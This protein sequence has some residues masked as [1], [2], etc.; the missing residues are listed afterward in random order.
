MARLRITLG[1]SVLLIVGLVLALEIVLFVLTW[2]SN[3]KVPENY[4][5]S[6]LAAKITFISLLTATI[7][8]LHRLFLD[9]VRNVSRS[10]ASGPTSPGES[11][12]AKAS[13]LAAIV[14]EYRFYYLL[15]FSAILTTFV[16]IL[17]DTYI[18]VGSTA[19]TLQVLSLS[20]AESGLVLLLVFLSYFIVKALLGMGALLRSGSAT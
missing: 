10:E 3:A 13:Q 14:T 12:P 16:A 19:R 1:E 8:F 2:F 18:A 9:E 20:S 11:E 5:P 17:A 4:L 6:L 7:T 15:I